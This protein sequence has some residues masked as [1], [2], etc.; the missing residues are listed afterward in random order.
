MSKNFDL[1][2]LISYLGLIPYLTLLVDKTFFNQ[3]QTNII[4]DFYI[5]YSLI[6][7]VFIGAINWSLTQQVSNLL[8]LY[9]VLPSVFAVLVI[10]LQIYFFSYFFV[11][12]ILILFILSQLF[13]DF[14]YIY[15]SNEN[16]NI[17][18]K[19]R[20]PLSFIIC[21]SLAINLVE[22]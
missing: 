12:L 6:I 18:F 13:I 19:L 8:L 15:N 10:V 2:F 21:F 14:N 17:F 16:K 4:D 11:S 20:L 7:I 9:G 5:Y 22:L 1:R 3:V